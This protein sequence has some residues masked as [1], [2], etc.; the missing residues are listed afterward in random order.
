MLYIKHSSV[1]QGFSEVALCGRITDLIHLLDIQVFQCF[2]RSVSFLFHCALL[3]P[4]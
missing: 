2:L 1:L 4:F 3:G